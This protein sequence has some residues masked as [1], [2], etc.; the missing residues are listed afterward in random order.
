MELLPEQY[1][2]Q[3]FRLPELKRCFLAS[4]KRN[5]QDGAAPPLRYSPDSCLRLAAGT[6]KAVNHILALHHFRFYC[7]LCTK[8]Q[9]LRVR[10]H[11]PPVHPKHRVKSV[12]WDLVKEIDPVATLAVSHPTLLTAT[13]N[14]ELVE[15]NTWL[16]L[17]GDPLDSDFLRCQQEAR[18]ICSRVNRALADTEYT[19]RCGVCKLCRPSGNESYHLPQLIRPFDPTKPD[20]GPWPY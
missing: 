8:C 2:E 1:Q 14:Q 13:D 20:K 6:C 10:K 11:L 7:N 15:S 18:L 16:L 19:F 5:W 12:V 17:G 9:Q 3:V 4:L